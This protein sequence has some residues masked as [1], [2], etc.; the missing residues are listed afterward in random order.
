M[1]QPTHQL[2]T[3]TQLTKLSKLSKLS[4]LPEHFVF[5]PVE[6]TGLE[7]VTPTLSK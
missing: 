1:G 2:E 4:K 6:R 7:P 5:G 3:L